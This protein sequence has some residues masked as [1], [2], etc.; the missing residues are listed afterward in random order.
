VRNDIML[1]IMMLAIATNRM[2]DSC[3][4]EHFNNAILMTSPADDVTYAF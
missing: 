2:H 1:M 3:D 4:D